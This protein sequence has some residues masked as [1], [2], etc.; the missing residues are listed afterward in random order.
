MKDKANNIIVSIVAIVAIM[1]MQVFAL[2]KGVDGYMYGT[3]IAAVAGIA[4]YNVKKLIDR[5]R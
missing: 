5:W 1:I 4:G 3:A 2:Y